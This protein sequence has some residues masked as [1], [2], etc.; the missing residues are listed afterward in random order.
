[1]DTFGFP[2]V[3]C[4]LALGLSVHTS[5]CLGYIFPPSLVKILLLQGTGNMSL[6]PCSP[7]KFAVLPL[8]LSGSLFLSRGGKVALDKGIYGNRVPEP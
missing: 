3:C 5:L 6:S 2:N 8:S 1:M 7:P 4:F